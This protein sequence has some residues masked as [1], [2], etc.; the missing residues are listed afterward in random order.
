MTRDWT[1]S[2]GRRSSIILVIVIALWGLVVVA[3][4]RP[5]WPRW[6]G[7]EATH[8]LQAESLARDLDGVFEGED[9]QR[10]ASQGVEITGLSLRNGRL[11]EEPVFA[12]PVF[13]SAYLAPFV[14]LAPAR[15]PTVA[16]LLL[17]C[18]AAGLASRRLHMQ[19][20]SAAPWLVGLFLFASVVFRYLQTAEPPIFLLAL[21]VSAFFLV[22]G[23][24]EPVS[25]GPAE[26]YRPLPTGTRIGWRWGVAGLLLGLMTAYNPSYVLLA[27]PAVGAAPRV[28]R[29]TAL[30]TLSIG[31]I[32]VVALSGLIEWT[33]AGSL[34]L[35][36]PE[37]SASVLLTA[38]PSDQ[39]PLGDLEGESLSSPFEAAPGRPYP[40]RISGRLTA[41]NLAY[42]VAGRHLGLLPYFFPT[43][44]ILGLWTMGSG[45]T[46]LVTACGIA[47]GL[48]ALVSPFDFAGG[49]AAVGNRWF[50][51]LFGVLWFV[52]A[53]P[54]QRRWLLVT[55]AVAGLFLYP[56]WLAPGTS[57]V[58]EDGSLQHAKSL[59]ASYLPL[60]TSQR[61]LPDFGEILGRGAWVRSLAKTARLRGD[62][63]WQMEG[64]QQAELLIAAPLPLES[65]YFEFGEG[66]EPE[67]EVHGGEL[68][69]M[70]LQPNGRVAFHVGELDGI[71]RHPTWWSE[72][73]QYFYDVRLRM[74]GAEESRL[75]FSVTGLSLPEREI[76]P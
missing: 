65:V 69:N 1:S 9:R 48:I 31:L 45:R 4:D 30:A 15:G 46:I 59:A 68:G 28:H 61:P 71:A 40:V 11:D 72:S 17:L 33:R 56:V 36:F 13:Y 58:A 26:L 67:L 41:W 3:L 43:V 49:P 10:V 42:S 16:N 60:E 54:P 20:G 63:R 5:G 62:G 76:E 18:L 38:A 8:V 35:A 25:E 47:L 6:T 34:H 75:T 37:P 21:A 32:S 50:V 7:E 44:L 19:I 51:P 64:G 70:V 73:D 57:P 23:L 74:P 14:R 66:A 12:R 53:R 52:P 2:G 24:E 27:L 55:A 22:F 39:E 29:R